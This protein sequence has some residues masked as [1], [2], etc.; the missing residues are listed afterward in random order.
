ML[1]ETALEQEEGLRDVSKYRAVLQA[2]AGGRTTRNE[3][4][5]RAGLANDR[6]LRDKL[7]RLVELGYVETRQNLDAGPTDAVRY[8]VAYAAFRFYE[9][10]VEPNRSVLELYPAARVWAGSVAPHLDAYMGHEFERIA[11]E[12]YVRRSDALGLPLVAEWGRWE[13]VDRER[14]PVEID[15]V[16][17]LAG[18]GVLTSKVKWD[19]SLAGPSVH[20]AHVDKLRRMAASGRAWAHEALA[21]GAPLLYVAAAGFTEGFRVAAEA[22]GR[23]VTC[24]A[25]GDLYGG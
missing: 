3:I 20:A 13:G 8:G 9:R 19:Q 21:P 18:G 16:S 14:R 15:V 4:A 23:A 17:R 7:D 22:D 12:T 10:V 1:V 11:A 2:V 6:A 25:L 5:Q 24:W